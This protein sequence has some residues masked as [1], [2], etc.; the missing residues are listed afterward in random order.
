ATFELSPAM[1]VADLQ[2]GLSNL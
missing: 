1:D 2:T